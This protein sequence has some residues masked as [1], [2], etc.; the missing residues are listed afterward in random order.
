MDYETDCRE[1]K[2]NKPIPQIISRLPD[3][4]HK[5]MADVEKLK[6][7]SATTLQEACRQGSKGAVY[8]A[9]LYFK[10]YGFELKDISQP[11]H[12]WWGSEDNAVIRLHAKAVEE[13][14][15]NH[16]M[17]YKQNEG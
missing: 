9:R 15:P 12:Y 6:Q 13:Q 2:P 7:V 8:E 11:V 16:L 1:G 14:V 5:L 17:H 3:A 4:D 10:D